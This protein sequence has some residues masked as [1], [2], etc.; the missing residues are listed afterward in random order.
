MKETFKKIWKRIKLN[1]MLL[2][3]IALSISLI[4]VSIRLNTRKQQVSELVQL[5]KD[6]LS[7]VKKLTK[8]LEYYKMTKERDVFKLTDIPYGKVIYMHGVPEFRNDGLLAFDTLRRY[9]YYDVGIF[10]V[11]NLCVY[12]LRVPAYAQGLFGIGTM[13]GIKPKSKRKNNSKRRST[14]PKDLNYVNFQEKN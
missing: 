14:N 1:L 7:M 3:V 9:D 13:V 11:I 2:L 10:S 8:F 12:K 6:N 5:N 4:F